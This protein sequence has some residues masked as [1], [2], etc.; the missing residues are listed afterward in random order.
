MGIQTTTV[1][2]ATG[3]T[4]SGVLTL[5]MHTGC[6]KTERQHPKCHLQLGDRV[7]RARC[8]A[9]ARAVP[10]VAP[11]RPGPAREDAHAACGSHLRSAK[12]PGAPAAGRL[13]SASPGA[14]SSEDPVFGPF[15]SE[16]WLLMLCLTLFNVFFFFC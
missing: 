14:L 12:A 1:F 8:P 6:G 16:A 11:A 9:P 15:H 10:A 13:W 7:P 5:G 3:R 4:Y 2:Y